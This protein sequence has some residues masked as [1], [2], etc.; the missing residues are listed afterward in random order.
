MLIV[1]D[2]ECVHLRKETHGRSL[3]QVTVERPTMGFRGWNVWWE[4]TTLYKSR[5]VG[6]HVHIGLTILHFCIT[7]CMQDI[8]WP[9]NWM[10]MCRVCD[11]DLILIRLV[12][13]L[14]LPWTLL[15][16]PPPP[17][18]PQNLQAFTGGSFS[19]PCT[20][21]NHII[22]SMYWQLIAISSSC[23]HVY[24]IP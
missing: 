24:R 4:C 12:V 17:P 15:I 1:F 8:A 9:A 18:T 20:F 23:K 21:S 5:L 2:Q 6:S 16:C 7:K 3:Y 11:S 13:S 22:S 14:T 19:Q 10:S